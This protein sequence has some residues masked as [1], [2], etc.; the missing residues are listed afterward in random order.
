MSL[1]S[2][3]G[4]VSKDQSFLSKQDETQA[5]PEVPKRPLKM[6][7]DITSGESKVSAKLPTS[8]NPSDFHKLFQSMD[9]QTKGKITAKELQQAFEIF[10]GKHFSDAACK[11]VVRLFDLDKAGGLDIKEFEVLYFCVKQWVGAFNAYDRDKT[12]FLSET[13]LDYALRQMDINFS[14]EFI[15]FLI[16]RSDPQ[17]R[18]ISLDQFIV[19]CVQVQKFTEEFKV[20]DQN[21]TGNISLRYEDFLELIMRCF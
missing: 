14:K 19:F 8:V 21:Y 3:P 6:Y 18:K 16:S 5:N 12:G 17:A 13:E 15:K 11:F 20:R 9:T 10:Q 1:G 2:Q 4:S 7:G